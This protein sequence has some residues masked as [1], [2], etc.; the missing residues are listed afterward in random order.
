M[1]ERGDDFYVMHMIECIGNIDED[2][3][4]DE[5][6]LRGSRT[7]R[8]AVMRNLQLLGE[9]SK[10]VS[11]ATQARFPSIPW[12]D[13]ADFR[14]VLVHGYVDVDLDQVWRIIEKNLPPLKAELEV[15]LRALRPHS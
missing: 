7:I 10:R 5:A 12:R 14:N 1:S 4:G 15:A 9:S 3:R 11:T 13:I 2:T 6:T 8:D